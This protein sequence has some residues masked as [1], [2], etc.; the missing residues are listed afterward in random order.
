MFDIADA[1]LLLGLIFISKCVFGKGSGPAFF[2][3][4]GGVFLVVFSLMRVIEH[5]AT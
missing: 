3:Y 5:L 4:G 2:F 1:F